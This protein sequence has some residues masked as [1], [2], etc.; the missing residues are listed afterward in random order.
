M[1]TVLFWEKPGCVNNAR[2]KRL[3]QEA[4]HTVLARDL[5][6]EPW[7]AQS[8][9]PFFGRL[10]VADWFNRAAPG[11]KDGSVLPECLDEE[12]AL[13]L[14]VS[15]PLLIRRP[16]MQV[17]DQRRTGFV[18]ETVAAWIGLRPAAAPRGDL[19]SCPKGHAETAGGC[20]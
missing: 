8:L 16:L 2:Q 18:P 15:Q 6:A 7:T 5:L 3:L 13:A 12:T 17:G 1:A 9:R 19:E 14:M 10:P 20:P 11:V 4:G